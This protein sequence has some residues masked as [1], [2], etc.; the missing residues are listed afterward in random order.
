M[1]ERR[2]GKRPMGAV[3]EPD[4]AESSAHAERR[5]RQERE[6]A[7]RLNSD[8]LSDEELEEVLAKGTLS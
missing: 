7:Q 8:F 4:E 2:K 6:V 5:A 3:D 1:P